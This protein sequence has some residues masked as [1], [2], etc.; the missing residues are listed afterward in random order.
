MISSFFSRTKPINYVVLVAFTVFLYLLA[1]ILF[2]DVTKSI[3]ALL[4]KL[5]ALAALLLTIF[6]INPILVRNKLAELNSLTMLFFVLLLA[7]FLPLL[8][9]DALIISNFLVVLSLNQ[10]LSLRDE[11]RS[12]YKIFEAAFLVLIASLFNEWALA[13]FVP[14]YFGVYAYCP[15][16]LRHWLMPVAAFAA[17]ALLV[18]AYGSINH[19]FQWISERYSFQFNDK[20]GIS[21]YY[22]LAAYAVLALVVFTIVMIK[23]GNRGIGRIVSLRIVSVYLFVGLAVALIAKEYAMYAICYSF[24]ATAI[25]LSNYLE[26]IQKKRFKE[27]LLMVLIIIPIVLVGTYLFNSVSL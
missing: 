23:L 3:I 13:F 2:A 7:A 21:I 1:T 8:Q 14:L 12:K 24:F 20:L 11:K 26:T 6:C 4:P 27:A 25:F 5:A 22:G 9:F 10:V 19:G 18:M 16:Q 17:M 15:G